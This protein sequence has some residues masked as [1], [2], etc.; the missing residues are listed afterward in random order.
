MLPLPRLLALL[1]LLAA[2]ELRAGSDATPLLPERLY[3]GVGRAI[4]VRV[5]ADGEAK[6][7]LVD[8]RSGATIASAPAASGRVD[9][10]TLMPILWTEPPAGVCFVQLVV[11]GVHV[12]PPLV[13]EPLRPPARA[14]DQLTATIRRA[15]LDDAS[16]LLAALLETP[17]GKRRALRNAVEVLPGAAEPLSGLR[18]RV[19]R[20][21]LLETTLG[22]VEIA[23]RPEAAPNTCLHLLHL[24]E[25]GF[26]TDIEI[27]RVLVDRDGT[28]TLLQAG[29]PTGTGGGSPGFAVDFEP[30]PLPH[31]V[32][33]LSLARQHDRPNSGGSQFLICLDAATGAELDGAYT[34]FG[35]VVGG[36]DVVEELAAAVLAAQ[37]PDAE[38]AAPRIREATSRPA[39]PLAERRTA[40]TATPDATPTEPA[41]R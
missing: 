5:Q 7:L 30:S 12:G 25:G 22:D 37:A 35:E 23:L 10:A 27:H 40:S 17:V 34:V 26:Y 9:L 3:A 14:E 11:D 13:V 15:A 38:T 20:W 39:P 36:M 41:S 33:T 31:G 16:R 2:P 32:G 8:G 28:P 18:L 6:L 21:V 4:P 24:V 1:L 19:D 29:D